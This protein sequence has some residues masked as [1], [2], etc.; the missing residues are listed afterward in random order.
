MRPVKHA[1]I[2]LV[3]D[4]ALAGL[5]AAAPAMAAGLAAKRSSC[6]RH[7]PADRCPSCAGHRVNRPDH[8]DSRQAAPTRY[9]SA[10]GL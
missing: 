9:A 10:S 2:G 7:R 4:V 1:V 5:S 8:G 3:P 6:G